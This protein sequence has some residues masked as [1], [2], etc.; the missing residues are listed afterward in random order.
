MMQKLFLSLYRWQPLRRPLCRAA[1]NVLVGPRGAALSRWVYGIQR[2]TVYLVPPTHDDLKWMFEHFHNPE[3]SEMFGYDDLGAAIMP[4]RYRAGTLVVATIRNSETRKRIGFLIMYP[5]VGGNFN[6]WEFGYAI[7]D[8]A[9]R[10]AFHALNTTDAV[11]CYMFEHLHVPMCGW[12]T[13]ADNHAANA[14]VRRLGYQPGETLEMD[15][16]HYTIYRLD[17]AGW[18]KRRRKLELGEVQFQGGIGA[19]FGVLRAPYLPLPTRSQN[20]DG[21]HGG[22]ST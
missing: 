2:R 1:F 17:Q 11:G 10:N 20:S 9:D 22:T 19:A 14:V 15:G 8:P 3:I 13:R 16:H 7:P 4:L 12:R 5:P 6:F 21:F 18:A